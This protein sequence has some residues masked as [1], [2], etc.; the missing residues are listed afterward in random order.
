MSAAPPR[1]SREELEKKGLF[2]EEIDE[3]IANFVGDRNYS[4]CPHFL[5]RA[6]SPSSS[7][8][9]LNTLVHHVSPLSLAQDEMD[10]DKSG[11]LEFKE[12]VQMIMRE[13]GVSED[14][15]TTMAE[16]QLKMMDT[17]G[18][19]KISFNEYVDALC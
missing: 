16:E 6:C 15:A 12:V 7:L 19:Q 9:V 1:Y 4:N 11:Y 10:S 13:S 2:P 14:D 8:A 18:D 17:D 5:R 3:L